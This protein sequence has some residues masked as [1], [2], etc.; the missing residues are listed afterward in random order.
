MLNL[1]PVVNN[2]IAPAICIGSKS[3]F[4]KVTAYVNIELTIAQFQCQN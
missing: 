2:L 1:K 3:G 4:I